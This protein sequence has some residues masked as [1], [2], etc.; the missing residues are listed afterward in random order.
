M[1][2]TSPPALAR[3]AIYRIAHEALNNAVKHSGATRTSVT[4]CCGPE[5]IELSIEDDGCGFDAQAVP[6]GKLGLG[7]M[8]ER[9]EASGA[10][11]QVRS[12]AGSGTRLSAVW[13]T[14][15]SPD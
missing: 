7:I 15:D 10:T 5:Q 9:A 1:Q 6:P 13:A 14:P 3:A 11:L 12:A 8:R 4:L 2:V